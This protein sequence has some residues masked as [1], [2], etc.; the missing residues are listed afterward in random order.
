M[1]VDPR[2]AQAAFLSAV[3]QQDPAARSHV[4]EQDRAGDAELRQRV[5]SLLKAHDGPDTLLDQ[6]VLSAGGP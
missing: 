2:R 3:E 6:P 1:P 4:L 5:E